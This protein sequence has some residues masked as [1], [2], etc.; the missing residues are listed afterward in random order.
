MVILW[1]KKI[2]IKSQVDDMKLLK[3]YLSHLIL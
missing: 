3:I 2:E 1:F